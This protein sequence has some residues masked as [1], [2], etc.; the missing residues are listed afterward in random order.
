MLLDKK[1]I[2]QKLLTNQRKVWSLTAFVL[3]MIMACT[4][5]LDNGGAA[6]VGPNFGI[7][8]V[9]QSAQVV[10]G[11]NHTFAAIGGLTPYTYSLND[12]DIGTITSPAG[13][14]TALAIAGTA[15]IIAVDTA[16]IRGTATVTVL[17]TQLV[18]LP[19][20]AIL[21]AAGDQL[22]TATLIAGG[23]GAAIGVVTRDDSESTTTLPTVACVAPAACTVTVVAASIPSSGSETY[24]VTITDQING[25]VAAAKLTLQAP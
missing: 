1:N 3:A 16:G 4:G 6:L 25:D 17:P 12:S 8:I 23:A 7:N 2:K 21:T 24:T 11:G 14:F 15:T 10:K 9:P 13:V 20:S 22:F 18:V 19:G 5:D